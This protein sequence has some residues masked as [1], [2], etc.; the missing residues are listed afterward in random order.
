[1]RANSSQG[2]AERLAGIVVRPIVTEVI[3]GV[4]QEPVFGPVVVSGPGGAAAE[5]LSGRG[6]RLAP[7][8]GRRRR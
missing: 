3:I 5:V 6:A 7:L 4:V 2:F 8:T 1:V